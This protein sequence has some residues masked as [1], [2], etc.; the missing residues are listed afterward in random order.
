MTLI[1]AI[2]ARHSVR[3]YLDKPIDAT[4]VDAIRACIDECN[5]ASGL[6]MQLVTNERTA[7]ASGLARYGRFRGVSNYIVLAGRRGHESDELMGYYGEKVV[8]LM[9]TLGLNSCWVGLTFKDVRGAYTLDEG[10]K[11]RLV[12]ACGHGASQGVPHRQRHTWEDF[13]VN[14]TGLPLPEWFIAGVQA[15]E[16]APTAIH[17]QKFE[18]EWLGGEKV[19]A[20]RRMALNSYTYIDLGIAKLHFE[21]ATNEMRLQQLGDVPL[22]KMI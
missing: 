1:E 14:H 6:H 22:L 7:F 20:R 19:V 17:Q 10:E 3:Q 5:A 8:L 9:Q 11:M 15:A 21:I 2:A 4:T 16:Q 13:V 18:F 12:I